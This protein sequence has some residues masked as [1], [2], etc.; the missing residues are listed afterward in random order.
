MSNAL[1]QAAVMAQGKILEP[2]DI[3]AA[4]AELPGKKTSDILNC[5]L[6]GDS[7]STRN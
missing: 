3:A 7:P 4:I 1:L 2:H 6:G 5:P